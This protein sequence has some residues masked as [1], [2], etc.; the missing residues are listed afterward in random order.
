MT[1]QHI[2]NV[3]NYGYTYGYTYV[4]QTAKTDL[5]ITI[6]IIGVAIILLFLLGWWGAKGVKDYKYIPN[7]EK[8]FK[9]Y[10]PSQPFLKK[11][12]II[13]INGDYT[14]KRKDGINII[15]SNYDIHNLVEKTTGVEVKNEI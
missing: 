11:N 1:I 2:P 8:T 13:K 14:L 10:K 5:K 6:F 4:G 15:L 3:I 9:F 7:K 12:H